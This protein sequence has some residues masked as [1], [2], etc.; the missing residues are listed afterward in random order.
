MTEE[1]LED[2]IMY[3]DEGEETTGAAEEET[4]EEQRRESYSWIPTL[5]VRK[6]KNTTHSTQKQPQLRYPKTLEAQHLKKLKP[7]T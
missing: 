6:T 1:E 5:K 3:E 4:E 7:I 2:V